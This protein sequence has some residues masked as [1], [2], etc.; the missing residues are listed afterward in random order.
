MEKHLSG[1]LGLRKHNK[2]NYTV[3]IV[4]TWKRVSQMSIF[5]NAHKVGIKD[6]ALNTKNWISDEELEKIFFPDDNDGVINGINSLVHS[7]TPS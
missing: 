7:N 6:E 5:G 3:Q 1:V 4:K 2:Q